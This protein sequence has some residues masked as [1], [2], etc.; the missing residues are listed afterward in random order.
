MARLQNWLL[1]R[2]RL[3]RTDE[4]TFL[5]R[6]GGGGLSDDKRMND[7]RVRCLPALRSPFLA[8]HPADG[9]RSC[10]RLCKVFS[11]QY[12]CLQRR[13]Q[14]KRNRQK[15]RYP[16]HH[17]M[18]GD[19]FFQVFCYTFCC[20][21]CQ[22]SSTLSIPRC[23]Y[24]TKLRQRNQIQNHRHQVGISRYPCRCRLQII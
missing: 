10:D 7:A 18:S 12:P 15:P 22:S 13:I 2:C 1:Q 20:R 3:R 4:R 8:L 23:T 5:K 9:N 21:Y 19:C 17:R 24:T 11:C 14:A 6:G 16:P